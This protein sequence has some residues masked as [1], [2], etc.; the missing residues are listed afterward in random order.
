MT[1]ESWQC[2]VDGCHVTAIGA[3]EPDGRRV[4][5]GHSTLPYPDGPWT[6]GQEQRLIGCDDVEFLDAVHELGPSLSIPGRYD[7]DGAIYERVFELAR[8]GAA[9]RKCAASIAEMIKSLVLTLEAWSRN[10][11][12][13]VG[14][15]MGRLRR[16]V[17]QLRGLL[18]SWEENTRH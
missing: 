4:C 14:A 10:S 5:H 9:G 12:S 16:S 11:S 7:L 6:P 15:R 17:D 8:D 1:K 2:S 18:Q 3:V 13:Q